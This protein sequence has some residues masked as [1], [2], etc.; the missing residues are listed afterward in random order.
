MFQILHPDRVFQALYY[1]TRWRLKRL[2]RIPEKPY[3]DV[4]N[5]GCDVATKRYRR[6]CETILKNLPESNSLDR[7]VVA[8][9]GCG[10]CIAAA[11]MMLGLGARHVH[12][13][14]YFPIVVTAAHAEALKPLVDDP[15]LPNQGEI[16]DSDGIGLNATKTTAHQGLLENVGIPELVDLVYSFDVLEH[17]EDL[18]GFF[19]CCAKMLRPGGISLHKFDLSGHEYFEDPLPPLDFQTYPTWLFNIIFPK[20]RRAVGN[21]ADTIMDAM[22]DH[23]LAIIGVVPIRKADPNYLDEIWPRLRKEA[24]LRSRVVVSLLDVIVIAQKTK[25]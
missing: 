15:M 2:L 20:Y 1:G 22:R 4:I 13:I 16:L 24:R 19:A 10:D 11:D 12:L 5:G 14:E 7:G 6:I 3:A 9:I 8:E 23:G 18:D 21:F 17:V 25:E